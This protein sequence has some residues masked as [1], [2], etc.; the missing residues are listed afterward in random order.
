MRYLNNN[1]YNAIIQQNQLEYQLVQNNIQTLLFVENVAIAEAYSLLNGRYSLGQEFTNTGPW[2]FGATYTAGERVIMDYATH[3]SAI[4]YNLGDCV[5]I[6][7]SNNYDNSDYN[8]TGEAWCLTG[9]SSITGTFS[10]MYW[11]D[12]GQQYSYYNVS[13]PAPYFN[14]L[15]FYQLGN[16]VYWDGYIWTC[17]LTTPAIDQTEAMQYVYINAVPRNP[18]PTDPV[19]INGTYW[20]QGSH[21]YLTPLVGQ[22]YSIGTQSF[23]YDIYD[24]LPT[25]TNFW[26]VGDNRSPLMVMYIMMIGLYYLHMNIQ[27]TN[28]PELRI[29]GY[30]MAIDYFKDLIEGRKNSPIL[31]L[32]P[33]QGDTVRFGGQVRKTQLW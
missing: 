25:N 13:Y 6:P 15:N 27:P 21:S 32:Q 22:T 17:N 26:T 30:K 3:S 31:L 9:T 18:L 14:Y 29:R 20:I 4:T 2:V 24:T 19:N 8:L 1:D 28:V 5:I 33:N 10:S 11:S 12:L 16:L 7:N 23:T